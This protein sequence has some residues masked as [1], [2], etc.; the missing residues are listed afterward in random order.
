M[1]VQF[2]ACDAMLRSDNVTANNVAYKVVDDAI[3]VVDCS[4]QARSSCMQSWQLVTQHVHK[5]RRFMQSAI[6]LNQI[7]MGIEAQM[8]ARTRMSSSKHVPQTRIACGM[9]TTSL[10]AA[11][12]PDDCAP[13]L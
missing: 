5:I 8:L 7:H 10:A 1:M 9:R 12:M 11:S 4:V 3:A 2:A 13:I 6:S